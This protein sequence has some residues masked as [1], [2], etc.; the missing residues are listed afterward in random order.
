MDNR[1]E[2]CISLLSRHKSEPF[3]HRIVTCDEKWILFDNRKR[4]ALRL[5]K[6]ESAKHCPKQNIHQKKLMM[7]VWWTGSGIIYRTFLK[8]GESIT[9]EIYCSQLNEIMIQL[10][11]KQPRLVNRDRPILFQDNARPH[12]AKNTL[13]KLQSL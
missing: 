3:L 13:L 4:S 11:I 6:E 8:S 10:A 1:F 12:V 5:D 9:S 2:A 7:S